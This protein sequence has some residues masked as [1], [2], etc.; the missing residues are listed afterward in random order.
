MNTSHRRRIRSRRTRPFQQLLL[1]VLAFSAAGQ[2]RGD[3]PVSWTVPWGGNAFLTSGEAARSR[4]GNWRWDRPDAVLSVFFHV[5]RP[6]VLQMALRAAVWGESRIQA[7]L[8][9]TSVAAHLTSADPAADFPLG[10]VRVEQPGYVRVDLQGLEKT[11]PVFAEPHE[12]LVRS[13][14]HQVTLSC[15][16]DNQANRFYWGRRGPSVHLGFQMPRDRSLEWFYSELTVPEGKDPIGSFFMANGFGEGYFGMQVNSPTERR[17][18]FSVWSP[19]RTDNP[20]AIPEEQR[21]TALAGGPGVHLGEFGNE[22]S[23]GQ[24]FLVYPWNAGRTY[25]FLNRAKPDGKGNTIYS[26]WFCPPETGRWQLIASFRRPKTDKYL[27]R[28]HS[29]LENFSDGNGWLER[30]GCYGNQWARDT[31]G[32]W[33]ALEQAR[34]TGDDIAGRGYRLDYAGGVTGD[35]FFLRNGGF[36]ADTVPLDSLFTRPATA[37]PEPKIEFD[38]LEAVE[39][40]R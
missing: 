28:L 5:D 10:E 8:A 38:Q 34:F 40:E 3:E 2:A 22:G 23:G 27:T 13:L 31:A 15:V 6:A 39:P 25:R 33:H 4:Q 9:G 35:A 19:F 7:T 20:R 21:V 14:E 24:S 30:Q 37:R 16:Q 29:F 18:L 32:T 1:L 11:G 17:V 12:L 26:A 36:F